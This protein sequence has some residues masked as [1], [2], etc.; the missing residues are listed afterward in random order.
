MLSETANARGRRNPPIKWGV[1][2]LFVLLL[3]LTLPAWPEDKGL[4]P[5]VGQVDAKAIKEKLEKAKGK[6]LV[7]NIWATW[8]PPCVHEMPDLVKFYNKYK[9]TGTV[10]LSVSADHPETVK[11]S[12]LPFIKKQ[13]VTFQVNVIKDTESPENITKIFDK[14]WS[15]GLPATFVY[16]AKGKLRKTWYEEVTFTDLSKVVD[17]LLK[18]AK[19]PSRD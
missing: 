17:K 14:E 18:E 2:P 11:E 10:F 4:K 19:P 5:L 9:K 3:V 6:V 1:V 13:K 7:V 16:D 8:C 15:G 12:V